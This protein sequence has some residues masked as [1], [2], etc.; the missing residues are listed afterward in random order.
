MILKAIINVKKTNRE[1]QEVVDFTQESRSFLVGLCQLFYDMTSRETYDV[2]VPGMGGIAS[3]VLT[4]DEG[5]FRITGRGTPGVDFGRESRTVGNHSQLH[6]YGIAIGESDLPV[7]A[8]QAGLIWPTVRDGMQFWWNGVLCDPPADMTGDIAYDSVLN[9][10]WYVVPDER[11]LTVKRMNMDGTIAVTRTIG[12]EDA[13]FGHTWIPMGIAVEGDNLYVGYKSTALTTTDRLTKADKTTGVIDTTVTATSGSLTNLC[14]TIQLTNSWILWS[15]RVG[16]N[17]SEVRIHT[18]ATLAY[19]TYYRQMVSPYYPL[20]FWVY[21]YAENWVYSGRSWV[22]GWPLHRVT[23][24]GAGAS[25]VQNIDFQVSREDIAATPFR[26]ATKIGD[27]YFGLCYN[28]PRYYFTMSNPLSEVYKG[29]TR[30]GSQTHDAVRGS[31]DLVAHFWNNGPLK[32]I[33]EIGI[34]ANSPND[35][36]IGIS[37]DVLAIPVAFDNNETLRV[38]YTLTA[39]V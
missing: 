6:G 26:G 21:D 25:A 31:F 11:F 19:V 37:R 32:T 1:G 20:P 22:D 39:E 2:V 10:L 35:K 18:K 12:T 13:G 33:N 8:N 14:P 5:V 27:I 9:G 38:T 7:A 15:R 3:S 36:A 17:R 28:N 30:L 29:I 23:A 24:A 34:Y 16:T 4:R